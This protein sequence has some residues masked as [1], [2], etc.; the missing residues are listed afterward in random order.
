M[1]R[2]TGTANGAADKDGSKVLSEGKTDRFS[3]GQE[4]QKMLLESDKGHFSMIK[5]LHLADLITELNG[6]CGFM[7]ILSSMRYCLDPTNYTPLYAAL[8]FMPFGLFF[9]FMDGKVARWRHKSSLM[10]QEL[11]S[12]ADLISFGVAPAVSAFALGLRTPLDTLVLSFF[13]LCGLTRLARFNVT[14]SSLPKDATGKS[15][16]FEGTPIP[17]TLAMVAVMAYWV[18]QG[19]VLQT[20]RGPGEVVLG[21]LVGDKSQQ[22]HGLWMVDNLPGGVWGAGTAWEW[23]PVAG[24]FVLWGCAMVSKSIHIPKP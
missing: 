3:S 2:R 11:D 5:A 18:S 12:L 15:K 8:A 20:L 9:D 10:G 24:V 6:F 17:T 21:A 4:K 23:H 19:W 16:Y 1:S 7:S 22:Q 13:V 14:V